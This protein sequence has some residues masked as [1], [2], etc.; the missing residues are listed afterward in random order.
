MALVEPR[1]LEG[2]QQHYPLP[3]VVKAMTSLDH[4]MQSVLIRRDLP[5]DDKVKLYNQVLQWY[6]TYKD[7]HETAMHAPIRV[8]TV[9]NTVQENVPRE[10]HKEPDAIEREVLEITP[11]SLEKK[12]NC[13]STT[14]RTPRMLD[15]MPRE[16]SSTKIR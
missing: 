16:S 4:D 1:L 13:S 5:L 14:S 6:A 10:E 12:V 11:K 9:E 2:L 8:K 7:K 15:G 3:P